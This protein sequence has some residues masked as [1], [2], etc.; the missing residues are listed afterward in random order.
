MTGMMG[1][2][3]PD[4]GTADAGG[5]AAIDFY[6]VEPNKTIR[7]DGQLAS[8]W[9][10]SRAV[11][12]P[13]APFD[14]ETASGFVLVNRLQLD[15][16]SMRGLLVHE[17]FHVLQYA[18]NVEVGLRE[19][20]ETGPDGWPVTEVNWFLEASA[21][22]AWAHFDPA[23]AAAEIHGVSFAQCFQYQTVS[24][25]ASFP[26]DHPDHCHH[27]GAYIWSYFVEQEIGPDFMPA[28]W[29]DLR[30]ADDW[31]D[32]TAALDRQLPFA[33]HFRAFARRNLNLDLRPGDP[34]DPSYQDM[35]PNF[36]ESPPRMANRSGD[37]RLGL[38]DGDGAA[39]RLPVAVP[40]LAAQYFEF[41]IESGVGQ[42]VIDLGDL[43]P[44]DA[45]DAEAI[46]KVRG[47]GWE[48]RPLLPGRTTF[49]GAGEGET[50]EA[51]YLILGNH[52]LGPETT[53]V[54]DLV[55]ESLAVPCPI[56]APTG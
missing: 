38:T 13:T 16:R 40:D 7:R 27:Y 11:A 30:T 8:V 31:D 51:F 20:G 12:V 21:N 14:G 44:V 18:H 54:G 46:V 3:V 53:I 2:P 50:I 22:W 5:D 28:I 35:D 25:L 43:T 32:I 56:L 47:R 26:W 33:E 19:T 52:S 36:P 9:E 34:I 23:T 1:E 10:T 42:V 4:A 24:L 6:L 29:N 41:R 49:C 39:K 55:V 15:D 45:L 48:V 17:F 37:R